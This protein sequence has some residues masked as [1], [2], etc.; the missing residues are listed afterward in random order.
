L[1]SHD[2]FFEPRWF[3][4]GGFLPPLTVAGR[5]LGFLIGEDLWDEGHEVHPPA[6][7]L[8]AGAEMLICLAASPYRR[9]IMEERLAH[10]RRPQCSLLV[11]NPCGANDELIYDGR[12]FA[13]DSKGDLIAQ[14]AAFENEVQVVDLENSAPIPSKKEDFEEELFQA[15]ALGVRDFLGKNGIGHA[16]LG[17]SGGVDSALVA[18]IAAQ[19]LGPE[20]VTAV[21]IPSRYSDPRSTTCAQELAAALGI[22]FKVVELEP[23]HRAAEAAMG[24]LLAEGTAAEN[25]QAR[26][27]AII[28][29]GFVNRHGG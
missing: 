10:A 21:A 29:M 20:R 1:Q 11:A 2:V 18:V 23:L 25:V 8:E 22:G 9:R 28:L 24:D 4:P 19:A 15:L 13:L 26:L 6:E 14:L 5:R 16:F 17:L 7:L 27:R 12:S 3:R